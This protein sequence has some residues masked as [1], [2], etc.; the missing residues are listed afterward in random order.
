MRWIG[1]APA[2]ELSGQLQIP[3]GC[4]V[5][6]TVTL[7]LLAGSAVFWSNQLFIKGDMG[8]HLPTIPPENL[9]C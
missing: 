5:V 9:L 1:T 7:P 3:K 6:Q 2:S 8:G 4:P